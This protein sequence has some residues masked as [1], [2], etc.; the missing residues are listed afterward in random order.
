MGRRS[1]LGRVLRVLMESTSASGAGCSDRVVSG[2]AAA[3]ESHGVRERARSGSPQV[4][5]HSNVAGVTMKVFQRVW[6]SIRDNAASRNRS[7]GWRAG[8][9]ICR[10]S[11]AS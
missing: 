5:T 11:T 2:A 7:A 8:W 10:R 9:L 6:G 4:S 3:R 1:G